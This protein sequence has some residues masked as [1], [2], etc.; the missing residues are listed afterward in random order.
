MEV[1]ILFSSVCAAATRARA[2]AMCPIDAGVAPSRM[3]G[4]VRPRIHGA[5]TTC[6]GGT[7]CSL[8]VATC[9]QMPYAVAD[10]AL[11]IC[12]RSACTGVSADPSQD[13]MKIGN[14]SIQANVSAGQ[15][16]NRAA[17]PSGGVARS[18]RR[19]DRI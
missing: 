7:P 1:T 19:D 4:A 6:A 16:I 9:H 3:H 10:A 17:S 2:W 18:R 8:P 11:Q 5:S 12:S 15:N 14:R 13:Q